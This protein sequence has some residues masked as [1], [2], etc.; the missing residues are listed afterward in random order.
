M[1]VDTK[2]LAN[3]PSISRTKKLARYP[4]LV[5]DI[6]EGVTDTHACIFFSKD[7]PDCTARVRTQENDDKLFLIFEFDKSLTLEEE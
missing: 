2:S 6:P 1:V 4:R 5:L 3:P 7:G